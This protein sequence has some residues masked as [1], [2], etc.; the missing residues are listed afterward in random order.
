[1]LWLAGFVGALLDAAHEAQISLAISSWL[2]SIK[3]RQFWFMA[4]GCLFLVAISGVGGYGFQG[5]DWEKHG[6]VLKDLVEYP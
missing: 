2:G 4:L 6:L 5:R 3:R 1:L